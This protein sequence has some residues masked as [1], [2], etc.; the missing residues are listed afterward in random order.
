MNISIIGGDSRIAYLCRMLKKDGNFL[1]LYGLEKCELLKDYNHVE[2]VYQA[3]ESC[4][5]VITS[6]PL[7]KDGKK[8]NAVYSDKCI[9]VENLFKNIK[10]KTIITG[11]IAEEIKQYIAEEN[12]IKLIDVMKLEE[13]TV[14]N[15]I[16]TAEGA[17]Q[18]AMQN[19]LV[20]L[21]DSNC[22]VLGFGRIGKILSKMLN[23]IGAKVY[24]EARKDQDIA[25]I[26]S[27]GYNAI[28]LDELDGS[29]NKFDFIFNTIPYLILDKKKLS[30][31]KK[32][33]LLIDLASKPGGIDFK[34]AENLGIQ[35]LWAL[36]LPGKVAPKTAAKYIYDVIRVGKIG[37]M[38]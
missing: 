35:C 28:K 9:D 3:L 19:S 38:K 8:V 4:D 30:V 13:L 25:W 24:C 32:D 21:H 33:C 15:A 26:K 7:S 6:I 31:V 22:L 11:N 10:N 14:L 34:E 17:I 23:G 36:A 20:T 1:C 37:R 2:N 16:P 27:Y 12:N 5:V 18:L 29:L